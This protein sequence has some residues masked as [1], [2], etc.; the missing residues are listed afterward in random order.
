MRYIFWSVLFIAIN[1]LIACGYT[2]SPQ[3]INKPEDFLD[4]YY[5]EAALQVSNKVYKIDATQS[6]ATID[7]YKSGTLAKLGH[8]HVIASHDIYGYIL[9]RNNEQQADI[10]IPLERLVVD[11]TLL[12]AQA[13]FTTIPTADDIQ[14]TRIHMLESVLE[15][16]QYPF[17]QLHVNKLI[18]QDAKIFAQT[19]I[20]LHGI[21]KTIEVPVTIKDGTNLTVQGRFTLKQSDFGI[22]PY[23]VMGG[24]LQVKDQIILQFTLVAI[25]MRSHK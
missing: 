8:D 10:V 1:F 22:T 3:G 15:T 25:A 4:H 21:K 23:S 17:A 13:G 20:T 18:N 5:Q 7:V 6:I 12:R 2:N 19:Q 16:K 24:L 14:S 11:E 9:K